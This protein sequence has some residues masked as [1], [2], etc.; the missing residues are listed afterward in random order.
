MI[1]DNFLHPKTYEISKIMDTF[2]LGTSKIVLTQSHYNE[3]TDFC[4]VDEEFFGDTN[5]HMICD[6]YKSSIKPISPTEPSTPT[7]WTLSK[8]SD[9]L[10]VGGSPQV[11][12][13]IPSSETTG[14]CEWHI[15][16]D[17]EDYT[18]K[19]VDLIDYLDI[20]IDEVN[21]TFTITAINKDLVKYIISIKIYDANKSYYDFVEMEVTN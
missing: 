16:V 15:F 3:H 10:Y 21:H 1:T 20:S 19:M 14:T 12:H 13:A 5:T 9:K 6:F 17:G 4:G 2:P 18:D 7:T 11:I 8:V